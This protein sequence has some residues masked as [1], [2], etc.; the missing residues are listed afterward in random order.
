M[1]VAANEARVR[2]A[3]AK[4]QTAETGVKLA[5][6]QIKATEIKLLELNRANKDLALLLTKMTWL[7][8]TTKNEIG[9]P[10]AMAAL[11]EIGDELVRL[12]AIAI[13]D[14][15]ERNVWVQRLITSLPKPAGQ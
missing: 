3:E 5:E 11:K 13:P 8:A 10:R 4:V 6:A 15:A 2:A 9:T 14:P 12:L 1:R 7:Q